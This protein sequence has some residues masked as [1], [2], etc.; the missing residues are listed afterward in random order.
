MWFGIFRS[1][2]GTLTDGG[3]SQPR[4]DAKGA[5]VVSSED[6]S[7]NPQG[8]LPA[9]T[10][11]SGTA[12]TS[13]GQIV[14]ANSAR[15][16]LEIQNIGANNIGINEFGGAAAIG[17]AGTYTLAPG[18]SMKIRTNRAVTAIAATGATAFTATE[19]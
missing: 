6:G 13:S 10:D 1:S 12:A 15:K 2:P 11:R 7:G 17:T 4:L 9:G 3:Q 16:G 14:A 19:W 5:L 8:T 18:A